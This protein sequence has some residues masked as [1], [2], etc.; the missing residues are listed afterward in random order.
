MGK[1]S[2]RPL[3]SVNDALKKRAESSKN[4]FLLADPIKLVGCSNMEGNI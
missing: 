3:M 1:W 2:H 4:L